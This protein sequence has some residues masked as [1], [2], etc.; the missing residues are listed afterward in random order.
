[1]QHK[2]S[3]MCDKI[4]VMYEKSMNLRRMKYDTPKEKQEIILI[5]ALV[6]DIQALAGD[7]FND[8]IPHEKLKGDK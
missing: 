6:S 2:I 1:M 8:Q 3:E 5:N 4:S 7:I